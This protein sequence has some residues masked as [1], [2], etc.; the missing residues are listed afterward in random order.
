MLTT[1]IEKSICVELLTPTP[2]LAKC[3]SSMHIHGTDSETHKTDMD[4]SLLVGAISFVAIF[5]TS[6]AHGGGGVNLARVDEKP[7]VKEHVTSTSQLSALRHNIS[8]ARRLAYPPVV[9]AHGIIALRWKL[10][11]GQCVMQDCPRRP[12]TGCREREPTAVITASVTVRSS[13]TVEILAVDSATV[14]GNK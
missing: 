14:G 13:V 10:A 7:N 12:R 5:V 6:T 2:E 4:V 1:R 11:N 8:C 3:K 9:Q